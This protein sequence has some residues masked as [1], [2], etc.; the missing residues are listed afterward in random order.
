M[1]LLGRVERKS[2]KGRAFHAAIIAVLVVGSLTT[3]YPF[4]VMLSGSVRSELDAVDFNL[5]PAFW[6]DDT[7]LYRKFL[8][9]KYGQNIGRL[10]RAHQTNYYSFRHVNPPATAAGAGDRL[11]EWTDRHDMPRHW[12][13][14]GGI[15]GRRNV[16]E[17]LRELRNRL[18][19]R[20]DGHLDA[21]ASATS[22]PVANWQTIVLYTPDWP[23]R[24]YSAPGGV[25][26]EEYLDM[27]RAAPPAE[28]I[29]V[30]LA[31][32]FLEK[33]IYPRYGQSDTT[34]YN[35]THADAIERYSDFVLPDTVPAEEQSVFRREWID[36]VTMTVHPSFI[37]LHGVSAVEY[38]QFQ[39]DTMK[40]DHLYPLPDGSQYLRG[41]EQHTYMRFLETQPVERYRL[42]GP[43]FAPGEPNLKQG[44]A[45][46]EWEYTIRHA[47]ELRWAYTVRNYLTVLDEMV[48]RGR[49]MLNTVIFCLLA[50]A[51][52]LLVNPMAAYAM[53]R[54][55]LPGTYKILLVLMATM[56]FPPM[57]TLIPQ[58]I[59]LRNFGLLNTF[60][61]LVLPLTTN[62]Y[63]IFLLKGF[64]DS[65]PQDLYEAA[66]ID[67]MSE[68]RI[69]FQITL[70]LSKP[71]LAV[72][73]LSTFTAAYTMFLYAL[74]VAPNQDMW[75]IS[76]WLYQF[77]QR[78]HSGGVYASIV[79]TSLPTLVVFMGVQQV[80]MRGIA[81][82]TEK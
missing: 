17:R 2:R 19:R 66:M 32:H 55:K 25:I 13:A 9:T 57:V 70:A 1:G 74:L 30:N 10:N 82:P 38:E 80:I 76:T 50:M 27:Q 4:L 65:L 36:Y 21:L 62:G 18:H 77:Q 81:I 52:A 79:L 11:V 39:R 15:E 63:L 6:H 8:E 31:G 40:A 47:W 34:A 75:L 68:P 29:L 71:I 7:A 23:D 43:E 44:I 20:F 37:V 42:V 64:F 56:A 5:I 45:A 24:A 48:V 16:P 59:G 54:F 35:A 61:A 33:I 60:I 53:S 12:F 22:T 73:A 51:S 41:D 26:F 3:T 67:G 72:L 28:Y 58:F 14:L 49:I 46:A 69:F 78:S